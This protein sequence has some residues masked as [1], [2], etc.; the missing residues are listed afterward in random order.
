M[1]ALHATTPEPAAPLLVFGEACRLGPA[2]LEQAK[3]MFRHIPHDV[4]A[5]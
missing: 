3:V 5:R 4:K 2:R 1:L